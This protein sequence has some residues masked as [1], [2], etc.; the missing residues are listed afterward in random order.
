MLKLLEFGLL[1]MKTCG[2]EGLSVEAEGLVLT[3]RC[4][5][6]AEKLHEF[7]SADDAETLGALVRHAASFNAAIQAAE[8]RNVQ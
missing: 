1:H 4:R 6:G 7:S 3:Q 5:C 8:R 2:I